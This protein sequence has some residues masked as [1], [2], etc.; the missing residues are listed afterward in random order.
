MASSRKAN[1]SARPVQPAKWRRLTALPARSAVQ[2]GHPC[3]RARCG[4]MRRRSAPSVQ[5]AVSRRWQRRAAPSAPRVAFQVSQRRP[6]RR[7]AK[8]APLARSRGRRVQSRRPPASPVPPAR[9]PRCRLRA[10]EQA[11]AR[12]A[13]LAERPLRTQPR[14]PSRPQ[15]ALTARLVATRP[16]S[17]RRGP[18]RASTA[19]RAGFCTSRR[20][21][22]CSCS[23]FWRGRT[24]RA[25]SATPGAGPT[26][27][28][29]TGRPRAPAEPARQAST[30]GT[31]AATAWATARSGTRCCARAA[32]DRTRGVS[33]WRRAWRARRRRPPRST[34]SEPS[35][36]PNVGCRRGSLS[37]SQS[38][39]Q[40]RSLA[41]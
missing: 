13:P 9:T 17:Q 2:A 24:P 12:C 21:R 18:A 39:D 11:L 33:G 31:P 1:L 5:P 25:S 3:R 14:R 10:A 7:C 41:C 38:G 6:H 40:D 23:C 26:P 36:L 35:G 15:R 34:S 30:L 28:R 19:R 27:A 32:R 22:A 16:A 20:W 29:R 4:A 37:F 8:S